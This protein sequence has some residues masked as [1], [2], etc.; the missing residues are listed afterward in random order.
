MGCSCNCCC[1]KSAVLT[2]WL[3]YLY[4]SKTVSVFDLVYHIFLFSHPGRA[5]RS[6]LQKWCSNVWRPSPQMAL[7]LPCPSWGSGCPGPD[8][9]YSFCCA[10]VCMIAS[11]LWWTSTTARCWLTSPC[12]PLIAH[13][14]TSTV[15]C[16]ALW[17]RPLY[18]CHTPFGTRRISTP[19]VSSVWL[20]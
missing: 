15:P 17:A 2:W 7:S 9:D 20:W 3:L 16:S 4:S 12:P 13:A 1:I 10:C 5:P 18:F 8:R 6:Q 14:W 11:S 19:S